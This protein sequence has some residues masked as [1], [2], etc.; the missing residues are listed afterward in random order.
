MRAQSRI[1]GKIEKTFQSPW[2][3]AYAAVA[4]ISLL[5]HTPVLFA[6]RTYFLADIFSNYAPTRTL[7]R[8]CLLDFSLPMW[9]NGY[10][11][12][13]SF[14]ADPSTGTFY[15]LHL[16]LLFPFPWS[17]NFLFFIHFLIMGFGITALCRRFGLTPL[18]GIL[19]GGGVV[20]SG[21]IGSMIHSGYY[22]VSVAWLPWV[23]WSFHGIFSASVKGDVR[24]KGL[25]NLLLLSVFLAMQALA[26]DP[27][28][29][30]LSAF[31]LVVFLGVL[32]FSLR[33]S[34]L[35]DRLK[36]S[37]V[38]STSGVM[39]L[40]AIV[41]ALLLSAVQI[42]PTI[43]MMAQT[44]RVEAMD[45]AAAAQRSF[46]PFRLL[47]LLIPGLFG[48]PYL[49]NYHGYFLDGTT[50]KLSPWPGAVSMG[51][52]L[53]ALALAAL[54][55]MLRR[56][57]GRALRSLCIIGVVM[58]LAGCALALG[59]HFFIY[60]LFF[61]YVPGSELFRF[62]FKY[63]LLVTIGFLLLAAVTVDRIRDEKTPGRIIAS[64]MLLLV[65]CICLY[66][67]REKIAGYLGSISGGEADLKDMREAILSDL[68]PAMAAL[69]CVCLAAVMLKRSRTSLK[70]VWLTV[71]VLLSLAEEAR[72]VVPFVYHS[73]PQEELVRAP[74]FASGISKDYE[75]EGLKQMPMRVYRPGS[76]KILI[77]ED[78]NL[79]AEGRLRMFRDSLKPN[80]WMEN[81]LEHVEGFSPVASGRVKALMKSLHDRPSLYL[82]LMSIRYMV[83]PFNNV[84]S[85]DFAMPLATLKEVGISLYR[86]NSPF[87]YA[88][89]VPRA[90]FVPSRTGALEA[91]RR[92]DFDPKEKVVLEGTDTGRNEGGRG[93][94]SVTERRADE[95]LLECSAPAGGWLVLADGY[96]DGW[97]AYVDGKDSKIYPAYAA[98]RSIWLEPGDHSVRFAY[99]PPGLLPGAIISLAGILMFFGAWLILL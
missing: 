72:C 76:M 84:P 92:E 50:E 52:P 53:L 57:S 23:L 38:F 39:I 98:L 29:T 49:Q 99:N 15:P 12:G 64:G 48:N 36:P 42:M 24:R 66:A 58:I 7:L 14:I 51:V 82:D 68:V 95:V 59:R 88:R 44:Q 61:E 33:D 78:F 9:T 79:T 30:F 6:R 83:L 90:E 22:L 28:A 34:G 47:E 17:M 62:P 69:A 73:L 67:G 10:W 55:I 94:C 63:M 8:K 3:G 97:S 91:M 60:R 37:V 11:M 93:S 19:C 27:Q 35:K 54:P 77:D 13:Q 26:G 75:H 4:L 18:A 25:K 1:A 20:L 32:S 81:G 46:S 85:P 74:L 70:G 96:D 5:V 89:V 43:R 86:V 56:K 41:T 2:S 80:T 87:P 71:I 16:L 21:Y 45:F 40:A 31:S 65:I